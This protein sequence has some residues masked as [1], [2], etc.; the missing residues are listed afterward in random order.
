MSSVY[1]CLWFKCVLCVLGVCV[2]LWLEECVYVRVSYFV[3]RFV[4]ICV[5]GL[6]VFVS[7][8]CMCVCMCLEE[9]V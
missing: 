2:N 6:N 1:L 7:V 8:W 4:Y 3:C 5:C 9:S